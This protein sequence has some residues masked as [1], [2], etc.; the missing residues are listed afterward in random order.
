[1]A[2]PKHSF[3]GYDWALIVGLIVSLVVA[4]GSAAAETALTSISHIRMRNLAEEGDIKAQRI[5]R[6]LEH[7]DTFLSTILVVSN[8]SVITASTL[9]TIIAVDVDFSFAEVISTVLLSLIVLIFCEITPKTA[10]VQN[11]ERVA[12]FLL[13]PVEV[14]SAILKFVVI[15][16]TSITNAMLRAFGVEARR[17]GPFLT[18]DELRLMVEVGE[19]EGVLEEEEREMI[20][21]VFD[22]G[23]TFAREVMVPRIDMVTVEADDALDDA[24][25]VI[26]QGGFSR[27]PVYDDSINDIIGVLYAKDLLRVLATGQA[28]QKIRQLPLRSAYFVPESKRL[29]D[30]LHEMQRQRVHMAIVVDEYGAV[31]GL[32]TIEDLVEE[33]IGDIKD[34]Y[35]KEEQ[36]FERVSDTEFLVDAKIS[37]DELNERIDADLPAEDY[38]TLGGFVYTQLDKIPAVGDVVTY[39]DLTITVLGTKGRRVT[40]VK[41]VRELAPDASG[42]HTD[43]MEAV[44]GE[45]DSDRHR[46]EARENR[47]SREARDARGGRESI[48]SDRANGREHITERLR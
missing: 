29:D 36:I 39:K 3:T 41:I 1:M 7:P 19:E 5:R 31:V 48:A 16:L 2:A 22:L 43:H 44:R 26:V 23:D 9:A 10:A 6:I 37:V 40:K 45:R 24:T 28:P 13:R 4:A 8:L 21:N 42:D 27:I 25:Q 35:D 12:R 32:V 46:R 47:D 34:E 20:H 14:F 18:E 38:D 33:I 11:P 30:L 15:A 17:R